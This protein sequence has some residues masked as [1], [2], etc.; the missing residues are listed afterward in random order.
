[1]PLS[2]R[3]KIVLVQIDLPPL[4]CFAFLGLLV[5]VSYILAARLRILNLSKSPVAPALGDALLQQQ[6]LVAVS[7]INLTVSP[8]T[9]L[10]FSWG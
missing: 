10:S 5:V 4:L 6:V 7:K 1:M 2:T 9:P 3:K 8:D